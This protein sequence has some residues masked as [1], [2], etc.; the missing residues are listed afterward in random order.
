MS[1]CKKVLGLGFA[2]LMVS[3]AFAGEPEKL[4]LSHM[5]TGHFAFGMRFSPKNNELSL[6]LSWSGP[7]LLR[8]KPI[9]SMKF[10]LYNIVTRKVLTGWADFGNAGKSFPGDMGLSRKFAGEGARAAI[11]Q[12]KDLS[13]AFSLNTHAEVSGDLPVTHYISFGELCPVIP[14]QFV[15]ADTYLRGCF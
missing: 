4:S 13:I 11:L 6:D 3:T 8:G 12:M 14:M 15:N 5:S 2:F 9:G 7:D 1:I 10:A